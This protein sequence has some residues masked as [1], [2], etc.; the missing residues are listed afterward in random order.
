M[1]HNRFT[2]QIDLLS[3]RDSRMEGVPIKILGWATLMVMGL[4]GRENGG[5][6][7]IVESFVESW[8]GI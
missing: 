3:M 7:N 2:I 6:A 8:L 4:A 1:C 5:K